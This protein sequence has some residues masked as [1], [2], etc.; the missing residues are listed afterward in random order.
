MLCHLYGLPVFRPSERRAKAID[1]DRSPG[2]SMKLKLGAAINAASFST[3]VGGRTHHVRV[4]SRRRC[5]KRLSGLRVPLGLSLSTLQDFAQSRSKF[6]EI[7]ATR[8]R[9]AQDAVPIDHYVE[10][11]RQ[12]I[13][14]HPS[15][16]LPDGISVSESGPW[17]I[18]NLSSF[19]STRPGRIVAILR[20]SDLQTRQPNSN[21]A[22][23]R[24]TCSPDALSHCSVLFACL[25]LTTAELHAAIGV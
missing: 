9:I 17:R 20:F 23:Q 19:P 14:L 4:P 8:S 24:V 2:G 1:Q 11:D 5:L 25:T 7:V 18:P 12:P 10:R 13:V 21:R 22:I 3:G 15:K 6:R 16:H